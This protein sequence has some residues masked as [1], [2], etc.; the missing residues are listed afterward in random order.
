MTADIKAHLRFLVDG[1]VDT[2]VF[3]GH[4]VGWGVHVVDAL[5]NDKEL[6]NLIMNK[7]TRRG[8]IFLG[9]CAAGGDLER[10]K[11]IAKD[12]NVTIV[13]TE[14][15]CFGEEE[16]CRATKGWVAVKPNGDVQ[17]LK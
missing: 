8:V 10:I 7:V 12:L 11:R 13:T 4:L 9:H 1:S 15:E 2:L 17:R 3:S 14:G 6:R 16:V 5:E